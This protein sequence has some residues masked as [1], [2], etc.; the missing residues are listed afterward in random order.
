M[1][2]CVDRH[3]NSAETFGPEGP[4][5]DEAARLKRLR[6]LSSVSSGPDPVLDALVDAACL[7]ADTPIGLI[8]LLDGERQ[9]FKSKRGIEGDG[10]CRADAFCDYTIQSSRPFVVAD[11]ARD[12]RFAENPFVTGS[13]RIRFYAGVP[14]E[15]EPGL[16]LGSLCVLDRVPRR[17]G[18]GAR[19]LLDR[20]ARCVVERLL[21]SEDRYLLSRIDSG[22]LNRAKADKAALALAEEALAQGLF[23]LHF[24]PKIALDTGRRVGFEA[25]L[26]LTNPDGSVLGPAAFAAALD[27]PTLSRRIGSH[28]LQCAVA[29]AKAWEAAG[30]DFGHIAVNVSSSQFIAFP[31]SPSLV[32]EILDL[33]RSAGLSPRH[34]QIEVT[35]GV[36]LSEQGGDIGTQL[37]ALRAAGFIVAFDDFGTGFASLVHLKELAYDQIKIDGAFVR[38]MTS[39]N[40][41][42]AIVKAIVDMATALGKHVV[43]EGVE[44]AAELCA[45]RELG[46]H[47]GQGYF[48][49]RPVSA[50]DLRISP[51]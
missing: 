42:L 28:V 15:I 6:E 9:W 17:L 38:A 1:L 26:R 47:Y 43:A 11:A 34:I 24:Q 49:G 30:V 14:L 18:A 5:P 2:Q 21:Q 3:V 13:D 50:S 25:L 44:T 27:D 19:G 4:P 22:R 51:D 12:V 39:S 40:A 8:T 33:T 46:C 23:A 20:L 37:E 10:S 35:E 29:Q 16:R 7:A 36:M 48:F 45:L 41:D 32:D 31:G